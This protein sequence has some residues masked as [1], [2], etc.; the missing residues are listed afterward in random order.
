MC[1]YASHSTPLTSRQGRA[2][3]V[4][5]GRAPRCTW[6]SSLSDTRTGTS[7]GPADLA[8]DRTIVGRA[9]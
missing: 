7:E 3:D 6:K 9:V 5:S 8:P 1:E 4:S 2:P